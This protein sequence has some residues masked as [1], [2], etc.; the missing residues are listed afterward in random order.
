MRH[1]GRP[2]FPQRLGPLPLPSCSIQILVT[3]PTVE[4]PTSVVI[5]AASYGRIP[6]FLVPIRGVGRG[7]GAPRRIGQTTA[8]VASARL[9]VR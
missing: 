1:D 2:S 9:R 4:E 3:W 5:D 7:S 6:A 8:G